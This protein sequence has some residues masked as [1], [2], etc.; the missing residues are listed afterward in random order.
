MHARWKKI[1]IVSLIGSLFTAGGAAAQGWSHHRHGGGGDNPER[2]E[3]MVG[4]MLSKVDATE[5]QKKKVGEIVKA[6]MGDMKS[7]RER[8]RAGRTA[9]AELLSKPTVDRNALESLRADQIKLAD[10]ASK[11]MTQALADAAEVLTP[12]QRVKL[13]ERMKS[14]MQ[15]RHGRG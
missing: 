15:G 1:G 3:R 7:I 13:A 5:E 12:E 11:R 10:E 14:R 8:H 9:T 6:A 4:R 2:A